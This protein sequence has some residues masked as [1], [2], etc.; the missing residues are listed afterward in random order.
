MIIQRL[1]VVMIPATILAA[2]GMRAEVVSIDFNTFALTGE[3]AEMQGADEVV[4]IGKHWNQLYAAH[5]N[6]GTLLADALKDSEGR[7][8]RVSLKVASPKMRSWWSTQKLMPESKMAR[9]YIAFPDGAQV[10]VAGL[11]P[12]AEYYLAAFGYPLQWGNVQL[13]L[14]DQSVKVYSAPEWKEK[15]RPAEIMTVTAD[16]EGRLAG[17]VKG[18]WS[19]LHISTEPLA[20]LNPEVKQV[21]VLE[22]EDEQE[23]PPQFPPDDR[24]M[25]KEIDGTKLY[26]D[27]YLPKGH[28]KTDK[29]AAI[30]FFHGGSWSGGWKT[31][32]SPQCHALASHGMV[33][34][35]AAYRVTGRPPKSTPAE[36]VRDAKSA[37]R[38]V[39]SHASELGIDPQRIAAGGG[40]AGGH[41]AA[42]TAYLDGY[43]EPGEDTSV[44]CRPSALVLFNPVIDNKPGGGYPYGPQPIAKT[45]KGWSPM[46][47][48]TPDKAVPTIFMLG[49]KDHLIPVATGE[50]YKK[51]TEAA[52]AVCELVVYPGA[53]HGYFSWGEHKGK[54]L[55]DMARFFEPLGYLEATE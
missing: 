22:G 6:D 35:S 49:D 20:L 13:T 1:L 46:H 45:W 7:T 48:I 34:M 18:M 29:R 52:G 40:S 8:T 24:V 5:R 38:W 47:N 25:Y 9:D 12:S 54:A 44:S 4:G 31:F 33:A 16:A 51:I 2:G 21:K 30:V 26:M 15:Q 11:N 19:G 28:A 23:K 10:E 53:K 3:K 42:A 43:N 32:M 41:L 50:E 39:R 36:C 14:N 55:D 37:M 17:T 27:L